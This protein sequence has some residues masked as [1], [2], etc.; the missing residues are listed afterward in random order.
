MGCIMNTSTK[1]KKKVVKSTDKK[2]VVKK[3]VKETP[4]V[5]ETQ[6]VEETPMT[7]ETGLV[8]DSKSDDKKDPIVDILESLLNKYEALE[9]ESRICK[10]DL[11]KVIKLYQKKSSK[12]KRKHNPNRTPSGFAKPSIITDELCK[13]LNKPLGTKMART[14]VT[15]EVNNYIKKHNL[16][17]PENKKKISPEKTLRALLKVSEDDNS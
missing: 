7:E 1:P 17:N 11:K 9:K 10:N 5:E 6:V 14:D 4:V 12:S 3:T 15:R 2:K 8:E 16:Q 13:F